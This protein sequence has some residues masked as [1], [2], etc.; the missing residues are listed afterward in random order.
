M[1]DTSLPAS[2]FAERDFRVGRTINDAF[3]VMTRNF[4]VFCAVTLV[5]SLPTVFAT[6][7]Q[8]QLDTDSGYIIALFVL[9]L[10]LSALLGAVAQAS[11]VYGAF[12]D[13]RGR[14]VDIVKSV[15]VGLR[16][17]LPVIGLVILAALGVGLAAILLVFPG[18]MLFVMWYVAVPVCVVE[19]AGPI[20]SMGRSR[21]LTKGYRWKVF[22]ML[23]LVGLFQ[24]VGAGVIAGMSYTAGT[25]V[26]LIV[27]LIW[28]AIVSAFSA[29]LA[30][31]AYHDLRVAKEGVDTDQIAAVF[32]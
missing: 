3:S 7:Y 8:N 29:V 28:T 18:I 17:F 2:R 21:Q 22:G 11:I 13:M 25:A 20:T 24:M 32:E 12:E 9:S 6:F 23:L 10:L 15:Q 1:T 14:P 4:V 5:T 31:V 27:N 26:G 19:R 30:V 16:R